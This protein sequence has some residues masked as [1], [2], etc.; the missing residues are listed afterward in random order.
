MKLIGIC[1]TLL[2]IATVSNGGPHCNRDLDCGI[3]TTEPSLKGP[4]N[5]CTSKQDL[6][7]QHGEC[8]NPFDKDVKV[9]E[10]K[11]ECFFIKYCADT[12]PCQK[13]QTMS[14]QEGMGNCRCRCVFGYVNT[15]CTEG[16]QAIYLSYFNNGEANNKS[17]YAS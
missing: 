13:E 1:F 4:C 12:S 8:V 3:T 9:D 5:F 15:N 14:S 7:A 11:K 2:T 16:K 10:S 17:R 6:N